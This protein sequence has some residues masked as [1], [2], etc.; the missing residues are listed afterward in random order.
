MIPD[1]R[2]PL[3]GETAA[4]ESA[5]QESTARETDDLAVLRAACPPPAVPGLTAS[6]AAVLEAHLFREITASAEAAAGSAT[7]GSATRSDAAAVTAVRRPVRRRRLLLAAGAALAAAMAGTFAVTG[8]SRPAAAAPAPLRVESGRPAVPLATVAANAARAAGQGGSAA[9]QGSHIK[10]WALGMWDDGKHD[11]TVEPVDEYRYVWHAD[12][13]GA[14]KTIRHGRVTRTKTFAPGSW[15]DHTDF[16]TAPPTDPAAL[17]RYLQASLPSDDTGAFWTVGAVG[18]LLQDWTP[19]PRETAALDRVLA[20]LPGLRPLGAVRDRVG[21]QGQAYAADYKG[22]RNTVILDPE[23]GRVLG[24]EQSF[25]RDF[26]RY[27]TTAGQV[28]EYDTYL[29]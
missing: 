4:R 15:K 10:D 22:F 18:Y 9:R 28:E 13:S 12:G 20:G 25:T 17:S 3:P 24:T 21:R 6:R 8:G 16:P 27:R 23:T 26:P 2:R 11:P 14:L 1:P 19:G 7:A 29:S 5:L